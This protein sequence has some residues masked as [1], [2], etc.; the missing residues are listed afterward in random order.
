MTRQEA[1]D[2]LSQVR[3]GVGLGL[4]PP[5]DRGL[6]NRLLVRSRA[7]IWNWRPGGPWTGGTKPPPAPTCCGNSLPHADPVPA[8][9]PANRQIPVKSCRNGENP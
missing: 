7:P 9:C 3:L 8:S 2:R 1:W 5:L 6:F 4:L